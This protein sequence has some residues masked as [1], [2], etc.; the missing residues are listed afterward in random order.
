MTA[1]SLYP[2]QV[3]GAAWLRPRRAALLI[4]DM[5]LGK[6]P[7]ALAALPDRAPVLV[8][9]PA[10]VKGSWSAEARSWRPD[11]SVEIL[12]GSSSFRWPGPGEILITNYEILPPCRREVT[13]RASKPGRT[14]LDDH[15]D[16]EMLARAKK[17][18]AP[19]DGVVII[20]DEAHRLSRNKTRQT[21]RFRA[22]RTRVLRAGGRLWGLT[23]TP[24]LNRPLDLW[25][26]LTSMSLAEDSFGSFPQFAAAFDAQQGPFALEWGKPRTE[27]YRCLGRVAK[28]RLK[29]QVLSE[30]PEKTYRTIPV[31]LGP[32]ACRLADEALERLTAG[33]VDILRAS[34]E[35]LRIAVGEVG[36]ATLSR[37]RAALAAAKTDAALDLVE[38]YE[39]QGVPLGVLSDH[40]EPV[41]RIAD[42]TGWAGI[43]GGV[44]AAE[45]SRIVDRFQAG[46]LAGVALTIRAGGVGITLTRASDVLV[47]DR[48]WTP[49]L[50]LQA[51]DRFHRIGQDRGVVITD[52]VADHVLDERLTEVCRGKLELMAAI[53]QIAEAS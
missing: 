12:S 17:V 26:L 7:Q 19:P 5:G 41:E 4:D 11:Y 38:D 48:D 2:Y 25:N 28:R 14:K 37:A 1:P 39:A 49:A 29:R 51:E 45:R 16:A 10:V 3:E 27:V 50:N 13:R 18:P 52:L 20:A 30:L 23:G 33:G 35:A 31:S 47:I 36:F 42:R 32:D 8:I 9:C 22:L 46:E 40:R 53:D 6:T 44:S 43:H 24:L 34:V 21:D 15:N